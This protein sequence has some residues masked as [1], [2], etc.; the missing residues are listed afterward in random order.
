MA[1]FPHTEKEIPYHLIDVAVS[2]CG[3]QLNYCESI[4]SK[5]GDPHGQSAY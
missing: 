5:E 2:R 1:A 3:E 4:S